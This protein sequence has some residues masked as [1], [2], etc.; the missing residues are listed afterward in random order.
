MHR[1]AL[2]ASGAVADTAAARRRIGEVVVVATR[3]EFPVFSP[4]HIFEHGGF[5][6]HEMIA[7]V[8]IWAGG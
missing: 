4:G 1:D 6:R 3:I 2:L 5:S 8:A 7:P